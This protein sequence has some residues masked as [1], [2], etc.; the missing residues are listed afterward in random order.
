MCICYKT[1]GKVLPQ[2]LSIQLLLN[3]MS[4][5]EL[6]RPFV[7]PQSDLNWPS[8]KRMPGLLAD[9]IN[10]FVGMKNDNFNSCQGLLGMVEGQVSLMIQSTETMFDDRL[11]SIYASGQQIKYG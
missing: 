3:L 11:F 2:C 8:E 6:S 10:V 1:D 7:T 4:C 5:Q 9:Q